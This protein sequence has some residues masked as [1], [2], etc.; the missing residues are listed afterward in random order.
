MKSDL[1]EEI[2]ALIDGEIKDKSRARELD[3]LIGRDEVLAFE[4]HVQLSIKS[5][6]G[7][8]FSA[9]KAPAYLSDSIKNKLLS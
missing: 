9:Q 7:K 5:L 3:F 2:T 1:L 8:R 4:K 6:C